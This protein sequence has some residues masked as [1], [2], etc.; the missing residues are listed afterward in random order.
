MRKTDNI[1]LECEELINLKKEVIRGNIRN[2]KNVPHIRW[3]VVCIYSNETSKNRCDNKKCIVPP[4]IH[5][6]QKVI[7][8]C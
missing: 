6:A 3:K 2:P 4:I 5:A 1:E 7:C 8:M